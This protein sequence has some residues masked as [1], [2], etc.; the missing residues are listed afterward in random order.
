MGY[1]PWI[2]KGYLPW[3]G[4]GV[5]TLES[6]GIAILVGGVVPTLDGE[7]GVPILNW[8]VPT[9][10]RE[11]IPTLVGEGYLTRTE[12]GY[13]KLPGI[14]MSFLCIKIIDTPCRNITNFGLKRQYQQF[15]TH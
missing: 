3:L 7:E 12:F 15:L 10:D 5:L 9:L 1:L 6:E 2:G 14:M 4:E 8:G 11:G 13:N